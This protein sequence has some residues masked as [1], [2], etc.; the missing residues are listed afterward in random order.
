[1]V[2]PFDEASVDLALEHEV[3]ILKVASCSALDW[4]LLE[5]I[6]AAGKPVICST[7]GQVDPRHR[8]DRELLRAPLRG[9]PGAAPLRRPLPHPRGAGADAL[10][11]AHAGALPPPAGRLQ[12]A[13]GPRRPRRGEGGGRARGPD[14]RAPRR[15][16]PGRRAAERLLD[17]PREDRGLGGGRAP[18]AGDLRPGPGQADPAGGG[19]VAAPA[20][21][22]VLRAPPR[23]EGRA[24]QPA[25][26]CSSPCPAARARPRAG[27]SPR[28]WSPPA[29]TRRTSRSPR[30]A[31]GGR[32]R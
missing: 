23:A 4:P 11:A 17:G 10:H 21:P 31:C 29:T 27:S 25:R 6:A 15:P 13:R 28:R 26:T 1:M 5:R 16:A 9:G 22:R 32:S 30:A 24:G 2:T 8:Q 20:H 14:P 7:G 19:A 3:D 18:D 12:R